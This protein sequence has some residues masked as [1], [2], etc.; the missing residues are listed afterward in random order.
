MKLCNFIKLKILSIDPIYNK[1]LLP[2]KVILEPILSSSINSY[3][4]IQKGNILEK[5]Q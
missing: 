5:Q 2:G 1:D 3:I 4:K